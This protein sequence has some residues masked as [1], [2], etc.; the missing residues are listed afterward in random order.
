M[1]ERSFEL[2]ES[3]VTPRYVQTGVESLHSVERTVRAIIAQRRCP[4]E[5]LHDCAIELIMQQLA[6]MDTNNFSI[7][8]GAG[9][10]EGRVASV[11]VAR[12]HYSL[13]HGIGR[14][15]DICSDQPKAAGS[16]VM[17]KLVNHMMLDLLRQAGTPSLA[18]AAV[19]PMATGMTIALALRSIFHHRV[20]ELRFDSKGHTEEEQEKLHAGLRTRGDDSAVPR[21]VIWTR[22][23]QK[24]ALKCIELSGFVPMVVP[25]RR[26][27]VLRRM[28]SK[29]GLGTAEILLHS[30]FLEAHVDDV[31]A[32]IERVGG[33]K[34]V[35]CVLSTTSC[36]AP[37]LPDDV[38]A[39][40]KLCKALDIP[41]VVNNAY[42]VQSRTIMHKLDAAIRL[43]RVDLIVQSGD[44]NFLVPVGGA[45][46]SGG[47]TAV[48]R[49]TSL[50]AGRASASP[51]I[52]LFITAL[53]LGR[54]GFKKLWDT[55][56]L[57]RRSLQNQLKGFAGARGELLLDEFDAQCD[58]DGASGDFVAAVPPSGEAGCDGVERP[59][60]NDISFAITMRTVGSPSTAAA[61][62]A[63][64]FRK[65]VT[66]PRVVLPSDNVTRLCGHSFRN[67]GMHTDETPSCPLLVLAC[68]VGMTA[69]DVDGLM[70][71]LGEVWPVEGV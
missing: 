66:G 65:G 55:R 15:G 36:F 47:K 56:Y 71:R 58:V 33:P 24:T 38:V 10:R 49:A 25:L 63:R 4:E 62:G 21:Y 34:H 26:A 64:L 35:L 13:T 43:G 16:S 27:P 1:D 68:G 53:S 31:A 48:A 23:D 42:G 67:Y 54:S 40:A 14:S 69:E 12:R 3:F 51:V 22:I 6:V 28:Q 70:K 60:R 7:H 50:Y 30:Y 8:V 61:V 46:L 29:E 9:E 52:D 5:G 37:R 11:L 39:I 2:A 45:V 20:E 41:Y 18:S 17:Y 44:K 32:A 57:L 19:I 59:Q